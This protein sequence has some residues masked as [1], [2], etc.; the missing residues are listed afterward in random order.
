MKTKEKTLT[1]LLRDN[2]GQID[3]KNAMEH[4]ARMNK[5]QNTNKWRIDTSDFLYCPDKPEDSGCFNPCSLSKGHVWVTRTPK[6]KH[7]KSQ[8][9]TKT[10]YRISKT[11]KVIDGI[12]PDAFTSVEF[13]GQSTKQEGTYYFFNRKQG[14]QFIY[15]QD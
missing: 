12:E 7:E 10:G 1:S 2:I 3:I 9:L 11:G 15:L 6:S 13:L 5:Q 4:V 14:N 8:K